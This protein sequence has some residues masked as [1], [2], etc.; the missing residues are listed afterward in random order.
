M[1]IWAI[2]IAL[3]PEWGFLIKLESVEKEYESQSELRWREFY[4]LQ[5]WGSG[6]QLLEELHL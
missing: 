5:L 1:P 3:K 2:C 6:R 4:K